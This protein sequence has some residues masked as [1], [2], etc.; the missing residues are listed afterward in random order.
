MRR[1][2][3]SALVAAGVRHTIVHRVDFGADGRVVGADLLRPDAW[4]ALRFETAGAFRIPR[5][6]KE[7]ER[8]A[9]LRPEFGARARAL[10]SLVGAGPR[11]IASYGVGG[12]LFEACLLSELPGAALVLSDYAPRTVERLR[13]LF[14]ECRV[15]RHDLLRDGPLDAGLHVFHRIDTELS[16]RQWRAVFRRFRYEEVVFV[17]SAI[18][19]PDE[20]VRALRGWRLTRRWTRVGWRRTEDGFD[21]LWRRTH[22]ATPCELGDLRGWWLRPAR[23]PRVPLSAMV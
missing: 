14:P 6:R 18:L 5:D 3:V 8:E 22:A 9:A 7:L 16:N 23:A 11:T 17:A 13:E 1:P 12:A 10:A 19:S 2:S 4:D 21:R 15:D 20:I